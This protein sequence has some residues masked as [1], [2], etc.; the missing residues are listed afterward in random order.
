MRSSK[1]D[2]DGDRR[3][4]RRFEEFAKVAPESGFVLI[5]WRVTV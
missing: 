1:G 2:Q 3:I 4:L 5:D